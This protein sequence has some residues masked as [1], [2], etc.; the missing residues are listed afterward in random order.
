MRLSRIGILALSLTLITVSASAQL[1]GKKSTNTP[2]E[3]DPKIAFDNG[4]QEARETARKKLNP[5]KYSAT[6]STVFP[7]KSYFYVKE[8]EVSTLEKTDYKICFNGTMVK[9][10]FPKI[11]LKIYDKPE[12]GK[13]RILLY[14]HKDS[15]GS[16]DEFEINLNDLNDAFRL[17]MKEKYPGD[18]HK[19]K[20]ALIDKMRL[21]KVYV[22]YIIP[23]VDRKVTTTGQEDGQAPLPGGKEEKVT[24]IQYSAIVLAVGY[25]NL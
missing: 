22:D 23:A 13:G 7:F 20:R 5:Y 24:E 15:I 10:G 8:V 17:K 25:L 1:I 2:I 12:D 21:K 9:E 4:I 6:T 14:E 3:Q 16:G 19:D 11:G 18:E